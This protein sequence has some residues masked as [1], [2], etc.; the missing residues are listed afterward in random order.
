MAELRASYKHPKSG[1][2]KHYVF[3]V[4]ECF[5][6]KKVQFGVIGGVKF[7]I[8]PGV[9]V[10]FYNGEIAEFVPVPTSFE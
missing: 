3:E 5:D 4:P 8:Q 7:L 2:V 6:I 1:E 9:I 10:H